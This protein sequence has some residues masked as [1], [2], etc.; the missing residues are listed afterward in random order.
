MYHFKIN[1]YIDSEFGYNIEQLESEL[2]KAK[3]NDL[4]IDIDSVGGCV[5]TG[6]NIY[7][8]LRRYAK[9]NNATITTRSSGFVASIATI[10]FLSGDERI[11]NEFMQPFV[12]EP[13]FVWSDATTADEFRKDANTLEKTKNL[14]AEF[15]EA[16]TLMTKKQALELMANDTWLSAD[17]C[18]EL[19]FATEIERLSRNQAKLVAKFKRKLINKN[20][21][22]MSKNKGSWF[23][24]LANIQRRTVAQL[25]LADVN[26]DTVVFPDLE[27]TDTPS[28]DD[29]VTVGGDS[30]YTGAV[31]TDEFIFTVED[32][33]VTEIVDKT[34]V[35]DNPL[36]QE[37]IEI[38]EEKEDEIERLGNSLK[39][40][41]RLKNVIAGRDPK[42]TRNGKDEETP[43]S[44]SKSRN[45]IERL[46]NR[47]K[48]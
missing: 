23:E 44:E 8:Q 26:G 37:L 15:Y 25:E 16:N 5:H 34:E 40:A 31:E 11:V 46:K 4:F 33:V 3:G 10:I 48:Q 19:G 22:K 12:H 45:A 27:A 36:V 1:G 24:R 41:N 35:E 28:V 14:I 20:D 38:I 30:N 6:I 29:K 39:E 9:E 32:G 7:T 13:L 17:E 43:G 47:K 42:N 18:L 2:S 21:R